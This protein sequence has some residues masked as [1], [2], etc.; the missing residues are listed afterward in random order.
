MEAAIIADPA[1]I[2]LCVWGTGG[3]RKLRWNRIHRRT[4]GGKS[5]R[6]TSTSR[7]LEAIYTLTAYAKAGRDDLTP[8]DR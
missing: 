3:I 1:E 8:E 7:R 4:R 6:F 5:G 2:S